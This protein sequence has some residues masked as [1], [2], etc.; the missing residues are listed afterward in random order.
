MNTLPQTPCV[1]THQLNN[2]LNRAALQQANHENAV[3]TVE[4]A[5][6]AD[7]FDSYRTDDY[8]PESSE[9]WTDEEAD[10]RLAEIAE[11]DEFSLYM[12][13]RRHV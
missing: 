9:N 7:D 4:A 6:I 10:V 5:A 2:F 11:D 1:V 13:G 3:D 8:L 12:G